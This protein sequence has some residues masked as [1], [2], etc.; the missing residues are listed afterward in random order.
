M[1]KK[2]ISSLNWLTVFAVGLMA[3]VVVLPQKAQADIVA[4]HCEFTGSDQDVCNTEPGFSITRC[5]NEYGPKLIHC[6]YNP[7]VEEPGGE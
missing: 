4:Q 6:S 2:S 3:F 1:K 5:I 7:G